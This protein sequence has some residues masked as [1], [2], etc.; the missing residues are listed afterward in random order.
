MKHLQIVKSQ[1]RN[2][3]LIF[4]VNQLS[5]GTMLN[6]SWMLFLLSLPTDRK[7]EL[8]AINHVALGHPDTVWQ[9]LDLTSSN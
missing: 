5:R 4:I 7:N 9:C 6:K 1:Y 3:E 2:I 8:G